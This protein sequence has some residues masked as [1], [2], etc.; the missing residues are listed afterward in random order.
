MNEFKSVQRVIVVSVKVPRRWENPNNRMLAAALKSYPNM[1]LA[2]WRRLSGDQP[3]L[4]WGDGI[5]VRSEGA[6][7]YADLIHQSLSSREQCKVS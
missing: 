2:D 3:K 7:L 6:R 1:V 4:F 5:H